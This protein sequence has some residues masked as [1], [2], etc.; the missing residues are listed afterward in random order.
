MSQFKSP[1]L[2]RLVSRFIALHRRWRLEHAAREVLYQAY[3]P[4][5][6]IPGYVPEDLIAVVQLRRSLRREARVRLTRIRAR[7]TAGALGAAAK[8]PEPFVSTRTWRARGRS[9]PSA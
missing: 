8:S 2:T 3:G 1:T 4:G 7:R 5:F 9:L 6:G